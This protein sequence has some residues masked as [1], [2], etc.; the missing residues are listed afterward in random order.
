MRNCRQLATTTAQYA[1][2]TVQYDCS[3][4]VCRGRTVVVRTVVVVR[5]S[6]VPTA[7][8]CGTTKVQAQAL[9][10]SVT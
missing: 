3:T 8:G 6:T 1:P 2:R 7:R 5:T 9:L 4:P 10:L